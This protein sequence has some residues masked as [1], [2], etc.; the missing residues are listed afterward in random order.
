MLKSH[1]D[2]IKNMS[3]RVT[4][5]GKS[6][7]EYGVERLSTILNAFQKSI[8]GPM[9]PGGSRGVDYILKVA[10]AG[11]L[12]EMMNQNM[13]APDG[14]SEEDTVLDTSDLPKKIISELIIR[15]E[16]ETFRLTEEEIKLA[17]AVRNEKEKMLF[18][19]K[20]DKLSPEEKRLELMQ[21]KLG[22]GDWSR[23][24]TKS[25]YAYNSEQYEF[26]R[27][28]RTEM[29]L[30]SQS[31]ADRYNLLSQEQA[32]DSGYDNQQINPDDY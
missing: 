24:G 8:R 17:I 15:Y 23:G 2:Y 4:G 20:L 14:Y 30:R 29:G 5:V 18:I 16:S 10:I 1:T 31:Q 13:S 32:M 7:I 9:L 27:N 3:E 28:Q 26:E 19:N 22:L 6:K 11:T 25:I 12:Y 21:K